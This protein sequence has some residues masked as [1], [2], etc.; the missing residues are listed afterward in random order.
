MS[1]EAQ[2]KSASSDGNP[3]LHAERRLEVHHH[4]ASAVMHAWPADFV[5]TVKLRRNMHAWPA[6]FVRTVKLR[7]NFLLHGDTCM[8]CVATS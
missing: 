3:G 6:D 7:R 4:E 8:T 2:T 1:Y 5:R